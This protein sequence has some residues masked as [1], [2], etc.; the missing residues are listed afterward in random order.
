MKKIYAAVIILAAWSG[1][2]IYLWN[3]YIVPPRV[4]AYTVEIAPKVDVAALIQSMKPELDPSV[5]SIIA[6]A[7]E[8]NASECNLDPALVVSVMSRESDF[9]T[10]SRSN[11]DALGLMQVRG[12]VHLDLLKRL[13]VNLTTLYHIQN[14]VKAG[15]LILKDCKASSKDTRE[16]LRKYVGGPHATYANDVLATYASLMLD[17]RG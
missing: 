7:V 4:Q 13:G 11:A 12:K 2:S 3:T 15:C 5:C 10:Q 1:G 14:N 8:K 16:A 6:Q 17:K 9:N